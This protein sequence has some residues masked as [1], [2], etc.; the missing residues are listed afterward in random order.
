MINI[1]DIQA[2]LDKSTPGPYTMITDDGKVMI[3]GPDGDAVAQVWGGYFN[4]KEM[5]FN[6]DADNGELFLNCRNDI[7][8]LIEQVLSYR[9]L[10]KDCLRMLDDS[11][12][13]IYYK[14]KADTLLEY[15]K[16]ELKES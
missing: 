5:T 15:L 12:I 6:D 4:T 14:E 11:W 8:D 3:L 9:E 2:R 13:R 16:Q 1:E 10:L 7:S